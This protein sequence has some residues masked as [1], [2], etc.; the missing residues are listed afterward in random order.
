MPKQPQEIGLLRV[1]QHLAELER[2]VSILRETFDRR[3]TDKVIDEKIEVV[4]MDIRMF[5]L[6]VG[7]Q[8]ESQ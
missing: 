6:Y 3:M 1:Q 7:K 4:E 2:N 8:K 5:K